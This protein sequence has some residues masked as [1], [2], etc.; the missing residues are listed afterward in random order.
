MK[1]AR[2]RRKSAPTRVFETLYPVLG[3]VLLAPAVGVW[4]GLI[5]LGVALPYEG[6]IVVPVLAGVAAY[7]LLHLVFRKPITAYVFG[8]E[9]THAM[10]ALLSGYKVK[11]IFVSGK[12][13]EVELSGSNAFVALAPYCVPLY[14]LVVLLAYGLV[15]RYAPLET[16]PLW[17]GFG[18]GLTLTFHLAL[19]VHALRQDQPDLLHAGTFF[20]LVTILL[21]N[22]LALLVVLKALFPSLISF[23]A[24]GHAWREETQILL[25]RVGTSFVRL[26][27]WVWFSVLET[28]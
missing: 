26:G 22:G 8:H 9:L 17:V 3:L 16:P 20:S 14:T 27:R 15:R 5:R 10:A 28:H 7:L 24:F 11:S 25:D 19:T 13:G 2:F 21:C 4:F 23:S 6:K 18:I 1:R 12:G